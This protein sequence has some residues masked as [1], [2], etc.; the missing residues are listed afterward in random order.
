MVSVSGGTPAPTGN[1]LARLSA[2]AAPWI[3]AWDHRVL[4]TVAPDSLGGPGELHGFPLLVTLT[5]SQQF[6]LDGAKPDGADVMIT[7]GD[8][9]TPLPREIVTFDPGGSEGEIWFRADTLSAVHNTFFLYYGNAGADQPAADGTVWDERYVAIYHFSEDPGQGVLK[10]F[11]PRGN[12]A[13]AGYQSVWTS[14]DVTE[15]IAGQAWDFDG[16][17]HFIDADAIS[18]QDS[19]F[20]I[21]S[22]AMLTSRSTDFAF[23]ANPGFWHVS[24]QI[25]E[26]SFLP[27]YAIGNPVRD[28]RWTPYPIPLDGQYHLFQWVFD[29]VADT[30]LFYYDG[31]QQQAIPHYLQPPAKHFYTG[32]PIN[33]LGNDGVGVVGPMSLNSLDIMNGPADEFRISE[34]TRPGAWLKT[35]YRNQRSP[36]GFLGFGPEETGG[37]VPVLLLGFAAERQ[38]SSVRVQWTVSPEGTQDADFLLYRDT[39]PGNPEPV[40]GSLSREGRTYTMTDP[41]A[42]AGSF[43]YRLAER[44]RTGETVWLSELAV[45]ASIPSP[46]T[47]GFPNPLRG[48]STIHFETAGSGPV[49][50]QVFD[51]SGRAVVS[52]LDA[53]FPAGAHDVSWDTRDGAGG[54]LGPGMYF[55][56]L[57]SVDGVLTR[58]L[59]LL[60]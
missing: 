36:Q 10:D 26:T 2:T 41:D 33:P 43:R 56:R 58:K 15:G 17:T 39:G 1:P 30:I 3:G 9:V 59:I 34:G 23:Q 11:G 5:A 48:P 42:P 40:M 52:I 54:L 7:K 16:V 19:S 49:R 47:L 51:V 24:F 6:I 8:G 45:E 35:E 50:L 27:H 20:V 28:L 32:H 29:G 4:L 57:Q 38:G 55:L 60:N 22:W 44:T 31:E 53:N 21:S 13:H 18:T 14:S 37:S 25:N 46:L 12:D